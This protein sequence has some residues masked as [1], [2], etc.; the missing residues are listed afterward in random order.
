MSPA[1]AAT[2][3]ATSISLSFSRNAARCRTIIFSEILNA[4]KDKGRKHGLAKSRSRHNLRGIHF[5]SGLEEFVQVRSFSW[6]KTHTKAD[7][8][9]SKNMHNH[10]F[11]E[12][13]LDMN[14]TEPNTSLEDIMHFMNPNMVKRREMKQNRAKP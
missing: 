13:K 12:L 11:N 8:R 1:V 7:K 4:N 14:D 2:E 3:W 6:K 9:Q 5:C 10:I